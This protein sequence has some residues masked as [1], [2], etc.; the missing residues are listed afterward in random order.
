MAWGEQIHFEGPGR[1][2]PENL[3][4][5]DPEMATSEVPFALCTEQFSYQLRLKCTRLINASEKSI[6]LNPPEELTH[7]KGLPVAIK[8]IRFGLQ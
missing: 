5:F 4:F 7:R 2:G 8:L 6:E 1:M 3:D